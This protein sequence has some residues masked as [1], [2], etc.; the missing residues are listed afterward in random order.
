MVLGFSI[1]PLNRNANDDVALA[2]IGTD[3]GGGTATDC[4]EHLSE[5]H[6]CRRGNWKGGEKKIREK[7]LDFELFRCLFY[8][9]VLIYYDFDKDILYII[10]NS[11]SLHFRH[12]KSIYMSTDV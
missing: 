1:E 3:L 5:V 11:V 7:G 4:Q 8:V 10:N 12:F 6:A 9:K 2:A